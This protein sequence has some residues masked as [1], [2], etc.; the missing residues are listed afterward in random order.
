MVPNTTTLS[1]LMSTSDILVISG[2]LRRASY[3][4]F[5]ATHAAKHAPAG[6]QA[7]VYA[8]MRELPL[9]DA[10]LDT[11]APP[12][13]VARLR[14]RISEAAGILFVTPTYNFALPGGLKNLIDW[15]TRPMGS[16]SLVGKRVAVTGASPGPSGSKQAVQWLRSMIEPLGGV[17]VGDEFLIPTV[18]EKVDIATGH[19]HVDVDSYLSTVMS[20]LVQ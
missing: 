17:L 2:S 1:K 12:E 9:Y 20:Q 18:N 6:F 14:T 19:V 5:L 4:S 16:H 10:D 3:N 8:E 11:V 15:A 7:H 13:A